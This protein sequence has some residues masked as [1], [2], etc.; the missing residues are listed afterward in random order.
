[1]NNIGQTPTH[2]QASVIVLVWEIEKRCDF[3]KVPSFEQT[4]LETGTSQNQQYQRKSRSCRL[5]REVSHARSAAT[6]C[7]IGPH[8]GRKGTTARSFSLWTVRHSHLWGTRNPPSSSVVDF[9]PRWPVQQWMIARQIWAKPSVRGVLW[10]V[11]YPPMIPRCLGY[12]R[13]SLGQEE[14]KPRVC[15]TSPM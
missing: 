9:K 10:L 6:L 2:P 5:V 13:D 1:M 12:V 4:N 15:E 14:F 11:G 8:R 3:W 7:V